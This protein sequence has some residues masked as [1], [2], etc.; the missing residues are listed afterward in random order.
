LLASDFSEVNGLERAD[1]RCA[2]EDVAEIASWANR[3]KFSK[4]A[5]VLIE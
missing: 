2:I 3:K 4:V 1:V 5:S